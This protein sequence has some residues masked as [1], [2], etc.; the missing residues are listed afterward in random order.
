MIC[1]TCGKKLIKTHQEESDESIQQFLACPE[2][3]DMIIVSTSKRK[4]GRNGSSWLEDKISQKELDKAL[5][6]KDDNC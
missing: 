1:K 2:H 3:G 4:Y 6:D 5:E